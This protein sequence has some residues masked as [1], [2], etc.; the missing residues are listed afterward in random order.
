MY[1]FFLFLLCKNF[2][3]KLWPTHTKDS[4]HC[5][6]SSSGTVT[7]IITQIPPSTQGKSYVNHIMYKEN[8]SREAGETFI[9]FTAAYL[10]M[11]VS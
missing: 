7:V 1:T 9:I 8:L 2:I 3:I 10:T 4:L 6:A 5:T 11:N